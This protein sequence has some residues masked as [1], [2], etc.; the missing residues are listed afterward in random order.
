MFL[1]FLN[2]FDILISK[3]I[4]KIFLKYYF[5]IFLNKKHFK[6]NYYTFKQTR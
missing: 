4:F 1:I 5:Y 6:K 2:Y 3:I